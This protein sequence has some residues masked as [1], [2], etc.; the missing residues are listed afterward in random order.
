MQLSSKISIIGYI[1]TYYAIAF[2]LPMTLANYFL[3][4]WYNPYLDKFYINSWKILVALW[5]VFSGMGNVSLAVLRYRLGKQ[6]LIKA[7]ITNFRWLPMFTV[8]FGGLS[9]HLSLALLAHMF[10]INMSWGA[11]AKELEKSNFFIEIPKIAKTFKYMYLCTISILAGMIYLGV[12]APEGWQITEAVAVVPLAINLTS[13][14]LLP[15]ALNPALMIFN[16]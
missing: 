1:S 16:Y 9:F 15:F 4:G 12:A 5:V 14:I 8:F 7:L 3:V 10:S 2:G 6:G 11:T 13:H